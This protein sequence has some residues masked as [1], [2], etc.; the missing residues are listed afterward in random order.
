MT[1]LQVK[2]QTGVLEVIADVNTLKSSSDVV[3]C[4]HPHPLFGGT[5]NNKVVVTIAKAFEMMGA[6]P[7]RFNFRGVGQSTGSY[8][9]G[10]GETE[11]AIDV[12]NWVLSQNENARVWLVGFSFGSYVAM[13][14]APEVRNR[15]AVILVAPAVNKVDFSGCTDF[16]DPFW[17]I[18]AK[19]DEIVPYDDILNW[20]NS[21]PNK[22]KL[23]TFEDSSHFF[24][25]KLIDLRESLISTFSQ[26]VSK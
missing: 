14:A 4:L 6:C 17:V 2:S 25:G 15:A 9:H 19:E 13:K 21:L 20:S 12:Y 8:D 7:V 26:M 18:A 22:P 24:H 3:I 1:I 10:N 23:I 5:M 16:V 11:D